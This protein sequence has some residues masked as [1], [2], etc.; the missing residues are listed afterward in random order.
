MRFKLDVEKMLFVKC[1]ATHSK[2][3]CSSYIYYLLVKKN[4]YIYIRVVI[5]EP[6]QAAMAIAGLFVL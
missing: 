3:L 6:K 1:V 4:I 5:Y 2:L